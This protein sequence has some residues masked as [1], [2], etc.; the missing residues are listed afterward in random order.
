[1]ESAC[2][3]LADSSSILDMIHNE[4]YLLSRTIESDVIHCWCPSFHWSSQMCPQI[5]SRDDCIHGS[6][7]CYQCVFHGH[8]GAWTADCQSG[9]SRSK[10]WSPCLLSGRACCVVGL[11]RCFQRSHNCGDLMFRF[12]KRWESWCSRKATVPRLE[13]LKWTRWERKQSPGRESR[14]PGPAATREV[15][16]LGR[17]RGSQVVLC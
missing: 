9:E 3:I 8:Y 11:S 4:R 12:K 13:C 10:Y 7:V 1:M 16:R 5:E 14:G 17:H 2:F 6:P 15:G